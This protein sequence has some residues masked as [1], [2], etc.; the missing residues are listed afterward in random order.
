MEQGGTGSVTFR[1]TGKLWHE[2]A[3]VR[4]QQLCH[5]H[6]HVSQSTVLLSTS[7]QVGAGVS[8]CFKR[9][10]KYKIMCGGSVILI[11]SGQRDTAGN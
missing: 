8:G 9:E 10:S 4:W 3:Q 1:V 7:P 11:L 5:L 6:T 2:L